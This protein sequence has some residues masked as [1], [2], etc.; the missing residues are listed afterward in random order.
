[1]PLFFAS[2][3]LISFPVRQSSTQFEKPKTFSIIH[4]PIILTTPEFIST[5]PNFAFL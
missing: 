1:M 5:C 2:S 4:G 3:P